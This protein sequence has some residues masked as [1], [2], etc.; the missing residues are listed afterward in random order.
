MF[1]GARVDE[2]SAQP[3]AKSDVVSATITNMLAADGCSY[4]VTIDGVD[5]APDA[6]STDRM[7]RIV[8]FGVW[9][10]EITYSLTGNV[11]QVECGFGQT[12]QLP[13]ITVRVRRIIVDQG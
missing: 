8:P 4:P 5:Y 11:G 12:I 1:A 10:A 2:A 6:Q 3:A 9:D 7:R 13:E